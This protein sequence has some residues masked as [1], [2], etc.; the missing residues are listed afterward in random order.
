M[1]DLELDIYELKSGFCRL[2]ETEMTGLGLKCMLFR[3]SAVIVEI[4]SDF[5]CRI[6]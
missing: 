6:E 1:W 3:H 4:F 2:L 5:H